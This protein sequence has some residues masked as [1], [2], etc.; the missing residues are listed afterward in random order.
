[1]PSCTPDEDLDRLDL[2]SSDGGVLLD[3]TGQR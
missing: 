2:D 3:S 1:M